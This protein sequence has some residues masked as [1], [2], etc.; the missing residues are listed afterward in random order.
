MVS[1]SIYYY[2]FEKIHFHYIILTFSYHLTAQATTA[3]LQP[4]LRQYFD[5]DIPYVYDLSRNV[6]FI[7]QNGQATVSYPRPLL[8]NV[9]EIACIHCKPAKSLPQV[10]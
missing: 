7:L 9:A 10:I 4:K 8:P 2:I 3:I 5:D 1:I 6:S